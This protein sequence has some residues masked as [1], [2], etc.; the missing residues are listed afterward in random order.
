MLVDFVAQTRAMCKELPHEATSICQSDLSLMNQSVS[1]IHRTRQ[2]LSEITRNKEEE[3]FN[4]DNI[5]THTK[6]NKRGVFNFIGSI[7]KILF[8]TLSNKDADYYQNK[9]S[10]LESEQLS[11]L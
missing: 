3:V 8:G 5:H 1:R 4:F 9:K 7:S 2:I 11:L 6:R 10:E